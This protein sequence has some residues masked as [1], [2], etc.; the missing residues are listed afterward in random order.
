MDAP[1]TSRF[2]HAAERKNKAVQP[3]SL[4]EQCLMVEDQTENG[5]ARDED[6]IERKARCISIFCCRS[7]VYKLAHCALNCSDLQMEA[8]AGQ[9]SLVQSPLPLARRT[10]SMVFCLILKYLLNRNAEWQS[11]RS[12]MVSVCLL[13]QRFEKRY[14]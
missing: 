3:P 2:H 6:Y 10:I 8:D 1:R 12:R 5:K 7:A 11:V 4:P 9:V 13:Q 14:E